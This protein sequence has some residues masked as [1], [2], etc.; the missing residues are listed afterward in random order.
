MSVCRRNT[1]EMLRERKTATVRERF[2]DPEEDR[3]DAVRE[4]APE[5]LAPGDAARECP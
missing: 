2:R 4:A 5:C 1:E 3:A